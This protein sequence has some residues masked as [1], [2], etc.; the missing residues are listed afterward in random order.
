[1]SR[2]KVRLRTLLL[3]LAAASAL[4]ALVVGL[5]KAGQSIGILFPA[6]GVYLTMALPRDDLDAITLFAVRGEGAKS[7]NAY[8]WKVFWFTLSGVDDFGARVVADVPAA[9]VSAPDYVVVAKDPAGTWHRW[10]FSADGNVRV[11]WYPTGRYANVHVPHASQGDEPTRAELLELGVSEW[12][13]D[14]S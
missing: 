2:L 8:H 7:V 10:T 5:R 6:D 1:M 12:R 14:E 13:L 11:V 9:W 3:L 4:L